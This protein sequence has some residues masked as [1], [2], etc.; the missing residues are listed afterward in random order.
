[1]TEPMRP[2][3]AQTVD[4]AFESGITAGRIVGYKDGNAVAE[5]DLDAA[6]RRGY[7][8]G[9]E[10]ATKQAERNNWRR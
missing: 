3:M 1:M 10:D 6:Y 2:L 5:Q 8:A 7:D 4:A 9:Y